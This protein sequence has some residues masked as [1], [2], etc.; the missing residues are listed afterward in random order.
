MRMRI[1]MAL[2]AAAL[3]LATG[4]GGE[5][6]AGGVASVSGGSADPSASASPGA[7]DPEQGREFAQCM[8]DN[9]IPDFPDPGPD[10]QVTDPNFDRG[11]LL[12][13]AGKKAFAA[14]RDLAPN[15]GEQRQLDAAEQEQL[16]EWAACM[17]D[18]GVD[19]PDPD[20]NGGG[21]LGLTEQGID[22]EDPKFQAAFEACKGKFTFRGEG[23]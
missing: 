7:V 6:D 15:G 4:C 23:R 21:F 22:L 11:K 16:R 17:R 19:M 10:G 12:S 5:A 8:R 13:D 3:A 18:N 1:G 20:P 14:C 9:G 2:A